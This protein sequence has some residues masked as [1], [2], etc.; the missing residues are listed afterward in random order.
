MGAAILVLSAEQAQLALA[1]VLKFNLPAL[2]TRCLEA[3]AMS[4]CSVADCFNISGGRKG[5]LE[6][7]DRGSDNRQQCF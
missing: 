7:S 3:R 2:R 1:I 5:V 6:I 4:F